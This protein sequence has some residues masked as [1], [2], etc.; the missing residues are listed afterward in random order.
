MFTPNPPLDFSLLPLPAIHF[1][2]GRFSG[3]AELA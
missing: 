2:A 3:L 1:G